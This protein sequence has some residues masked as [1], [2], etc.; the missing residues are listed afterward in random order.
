MKSEAGIIGTV[1][2]A[3]VTLVTVLVLMAS[4]VAY[5]NGFEHWW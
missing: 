4:A 5:H 2:R 1:K 3:S